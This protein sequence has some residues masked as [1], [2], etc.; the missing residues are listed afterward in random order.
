MYLGSL[1]TTRDIYAYLSLSHCLSLSGAVHD[2]EGRGYGGDRRLPLAT[3]RPV[4]LLGQT[5]F[6]VLTT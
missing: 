2:G 5:R 3:L 6:H 1:Q 4:R